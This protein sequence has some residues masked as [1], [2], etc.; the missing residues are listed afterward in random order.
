MNNKKNIKYYLKICKY[1]KED[2]YT[3]EISV[4]N[5]IIFVVKKILFLLIKVLNYEN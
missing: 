5:L 3:E 1:Y 4:I 2:V